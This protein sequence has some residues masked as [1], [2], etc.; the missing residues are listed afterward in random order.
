MKPRGAVFTTAM[1]AICWL[2]FLVDL[3]TS[4]SSNGR[5]EIWNSLALDPQAVLNGQWWRLFT[6]GFVHDG[7]GH[8]LVNSIALFQAGD[9]VEYVYGTRRYA[10]IYVAALFGGGFAAYLATVGTGSWTVGAS[11]AI[12]GV[13]GAMAVLGY[14]LPP[15]RRELLRSAV[16]PIVLVLL[17]GLF[18]K[19]I[20][21]AAHIGG[22]IAGS[23]AA[24][25]I[26]PAQANEMIRLFG[27]SNPRP[28][29]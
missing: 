26:K 9:F 5:G 13:F 4:R 15:L 23:I 12:M 11:G 24:L 8:I 21:N 2:I 7:F 19:N 14:K 3:L 6:Y 27:G 28:P 16:V 17:Y 22:L 25:V 1:I 10:A 18:M 20:S 29:A